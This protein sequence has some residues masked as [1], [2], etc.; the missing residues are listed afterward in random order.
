MQNKSKDRRKEA[1][2][3]EINK[4]KQT[5]QKLIKQKRNIQYVG[6]QQNRTLAG[7]LIK[8]VKTKKPLVRLLKK[9]KRR[10]NSK[11]QIFLKDILLNYTNTKK[12]WQETT[13][14]FFTPINLKNYTRKPKSQ[15]DVDKHVIKD[16]SQMASKHVKNHSA[17]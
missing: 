11:Q 3:T 5:E 15:K 4:I 6:D 1:N 14:N 10:N 13:M 12:N 7:S 9:R 2:R 8:L 16:Y 17:S